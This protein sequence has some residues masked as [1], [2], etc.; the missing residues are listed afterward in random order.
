LEI[1]NNT[2]AI[3]KPKGP[4]SHDIIDSIRKITGVRKVG[5]AGTLDPLASGVLVIGVGREATK[6]LFN[7][8]Q[9]KKEYKAKIYFGYTSS[10][11]DEDGEKEEKKIKAPPS[12][13][14][15]KEI[16]NNLKEDYLQNPPVYSSVKILG[17]PA[18][19]RIR[20]GQSVKIEPRRVDLIDFEIINFK[21]PI[22]EIRLVTGSG[23]YVR[24]FARD[25]G[26]RLD[27]G[28]YL[29]SLERTKV[30]EFD[31]KESLTLLEFKQ[32]YEKHN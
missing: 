14:Q 12:L 20:R 9:T 32:E 4:T 8:V 10:T 29:S 17:T 26:E 30:G 21:W 5:H 22:L 3:Y 13:V 23:F 11:D 7:I 25:I 6:E 18:H 28:A 15:L 2:Y 16:I 19:R 1:K 31:I 27:G 24:S